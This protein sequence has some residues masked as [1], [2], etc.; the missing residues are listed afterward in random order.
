MYT[1]TVA[2]TQTT[3]SALLCADPSQH[4][5]QKNHEM[6]NEIN[7]NWRLYKKDE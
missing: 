5:L 6:E 4:R 3:V 7:R 2:N 1:P